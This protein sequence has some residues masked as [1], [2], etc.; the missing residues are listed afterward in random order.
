MAMVASSG[1]SADRTLVC[2]LCGRRFL[3]YERHAAEEHVRSAHPEAFS[4]SCMVCGER[5]RAGEMKKVIA[6]MMAEHPQE[7]RDL[8]RR[9]GTLG[10]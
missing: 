9:L 10:E 7:V 8:F 1:D 6:H 2:R 3:Q 4:L 5:F